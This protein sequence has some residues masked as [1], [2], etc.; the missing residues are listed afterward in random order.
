[1]KIALLGTGK[2]GS[3]VIEVA[4][5][6]EVVGFD[7][8]NPPTLDKLKPCDVAISFLPGSAFLQY[9][10]LLIESK[11]PVVVGSTGFEWPKDIDQRLKD[12]NI[13]W[14]VSSNFAL[15]MN[16][17]RAMIYAMSKA[18]GLF[19]EYKY[20]L[21]EIH[22]IHKKD[23]PS[24]TALTW[25]Q[26][27]GHNAQISSKREGDNPGFHKLILKTPYEDIAIEH[28]SKDRRIFAQGAVWTAKRL[29][30]G[31]LDPGL[32]KLQDIMDKELL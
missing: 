14:V 17:V 20:N 2:T 21:E 23:S 6:N 11:L 31:D 22:H 27:L 8:N 18:P 16:I 15:G 1:M 7:E 29:L 32:H 4:S 30:K 25:Q 24:G 12:A 26:W 3:K 19:D 10:D 5:D 28:Q 9:I 13:G